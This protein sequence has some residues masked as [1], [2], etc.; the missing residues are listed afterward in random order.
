MPKHLSAKELRASLPNVVARV[1]SGERLTLVYRSRP[2]LQLVPLGVSDAPLPPLEEDPLYQMAAV[3][4]GPDDG[5][6]SRDHDH[7]VY[8]TPLKPRRRKRSP[9]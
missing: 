2:V 7:V 9:R 6:D 8:G 1:Q 3:G 5:L 4:R